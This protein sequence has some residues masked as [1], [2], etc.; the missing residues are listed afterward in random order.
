MRLSAVF[1]EPVRGPRWVARR[2]KRPKQGRESRTPLL[3]S[4]SHIYGS[5]P[6]KTVSIAR[7]RQTNTKRPGDWSF[8][9][10]KAQGKSQGVPLFV[11]HCDSKPCSAS[12]LSASE[13]AR[14]KQPYPWKHHYEDRNSLLETCSLLVPHGERFLVIGFMLQ[15][16]GCLKLVV[17][18]CNMQPLTYNREQVTS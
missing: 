18:S 7:G 1:G 11:M 10:W 4:S 17:S 13:A 8:C 3:S 6:R 16:T 12:V 14:C 2:N 15:V 9:L 5:I